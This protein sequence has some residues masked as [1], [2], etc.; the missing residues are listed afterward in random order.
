MEKDS[1][2]RIKLSEYKRHISLPEFMENYYGFKQSKRST[3]NSPKF[4]DPQTDTVYICYLNQNKEWHY[5]QPELNQSG[6]TIIDLIMDKEGY[7]NLG[8]VRRNL[9]QYI[10]SPGFIQT[11]DSQYVIRR[12]QNDFTPI[13]NQL[14]PLEHKD[15]FYKRNITEN[16]I[17]HPY[18][19]PIIFNK[20]HYSPKYQK[21]FHNVAFIMKN[22]KGEISAISIRNDGL[23]GAY[24]KRGESICISANP[25]KSTK[26]NIAFLTETMDDAMAHFQMYRNIYQNDKIRYIATQGTIV[27]N[28]TNEKTNKRVT[29]SQMDIINEIFKRTQPE[30]MI[31]GF[32]N[33]KAG[34]FYSCQALS[35]LSIP[36]NYQQKQ[37]IL[38]NQTFNVKTDVS[39]HL[40]DDKNKYGL[41]NFTLVNPTDQSMEHF[42]N[43]IQS[44][45]D[46]LNEQLTRYDYNYSPYQLECSFPNNTIEARISFPDNKQLWDI[47]YDFINKI[48]FSKNNVINRYKPLT[49]D[50]TDDLN[51]FLFKHPRYLI[52]NFNGKPLPGTYFDFLKSLSD[53]QIQHFTGY[54][55]PI[56]N[57]HVR[58]NNNDFSLYVNDQEFKI[59]REDIHK[60]C[61]E[62]NLTFS[63]KETSQFQ[64][65]ENSKSEVN[66][67]SNEMTP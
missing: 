10:D 24:G 40:D 39:I 64:N 61:K 1:Q 52:Q 9:D 12:T 63:M 17:N 18:F 20:P 54:N 25:D 23:K 22:I 44:Q 33:D 43:E 11:K 65:I 56:E 3:K 15:F 8:F 35:R 45:V 5:W 32:D 13:L 29:S 30:K 6:K 67:K 42:R 37:S 38:Q 48:Q 16:T 34:S 60:Y 21:T 59:T 4:V 41:L 66:Q 55:Q 58:L 19:K 27:D 7:N 14:K 2:G 62:N 26:A 49:K 31:L 36:E 47:N 28:Y 57:Y 51:A 46:S 50:Y 53:K